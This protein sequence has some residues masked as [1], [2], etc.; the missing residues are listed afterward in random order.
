MK[1]VFIGGGNMASALVSGLL[2]NGT[3]IPED[4]LVVDISDEVRHKFDAMKINTASTFSFSDF[5]A[6][7]IILAVKPQHLRKAVESCASNLKDSL[8]VSIVA[9]IPIASIV[10]WL[11]GYDRVIRVMPNTPA[12]IQAG[13]SGMYSVSTVCGDKELAEVIM[14]G[15]G[16]YIWCQSEELIDVVTAV[17]GSGPAYVFYF[18][19]SLVAAGM[20]L[21]LDREAS[22]LLAL[23][24]FL[25]SSRLAA[26][27]GE[28]PSVLRERVTSKGGTTAAALASFDADN[29]RGKIINAISA[30]RDRS[31]ELAKDFGGDEV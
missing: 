11:N 22:N 31:A 4:L 20:E 5:N 24:T 12:L 23:E 25:G 7:V 13:V 8:I 6:D 3:A 18:I 19:E 16:R 2:A 1:V 29:L 28:L 26:R 21:G 10:D 27:S 15:V 17:S 14:G 9:G 30:A